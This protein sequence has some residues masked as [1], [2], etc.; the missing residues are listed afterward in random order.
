[1]YPNEQIYHFWRDKVVKSVY[2]GALARMQAGSSYWRTSDVC[3]TVMV[4]CVLVPRTPPPESSKPIHNHS[5]LLYS[6]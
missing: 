3:K 2:V 5:R 6:L 4:A 1:M